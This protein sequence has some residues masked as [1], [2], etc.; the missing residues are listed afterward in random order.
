MTLTFVDYSPVCMPPYQTSLESI[1]TL[2]SRCFAIAPPLSYHPLALFTFTLRINAPPFIPHLM[3]TFFRSRSLLLIAWTRY[4]WLFP[5]PFFLRFSLY[6]PFM[7]F[8]VATSCCLS[9]TSICL[10][11]MSKSS[12]CSLPILT[13]WASFKICISIGLILWMEGKRCLCNYIWVIRQPWIPGV[14]GEA[15]QKG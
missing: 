3:Y 6:L 1:C 8:T 12:L 4:R 2:P 9:S 14:L 10:L 15:M 5:V 11:V 13:H 7:Y